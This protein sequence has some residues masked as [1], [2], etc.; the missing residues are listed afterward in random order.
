MKILVRGVNW[1]GDAVMSIPALL[2]LR[3]AYPEA[4]IHLLTPSKLA[5]LWDYL[6]AIDHI[7]TFDSQDTPW[8]IGAL[9]RPK[10]FDLA[11]I[12]PNSFRSALEAWTGA[13]PRR[14]GYPGQWRN[15]LLTDKVQPKHGALRVRKR[16]RWEIR[17]LIKN[18]SEPRAFSESETNHHV[19]H[20]L[21]LLTPLGINSSLVEPK[22]VLLG[23]EEEGIW[24]RFGLPQDRPV[25]ALHPGAEYGPAKRW[26]LA[27]FVSAIEEIHRHSQ[28]HFV[29]VGNSSETG[30][31]AE[32][33]HR[34]SSGVAAVTI[35]A[36]GRTN[37]RD[38]CGILSGCRALI[39]NDTGPMH[40]A[41]AL[42]TPVVAIF[43]ST[44][45]ALTRPL[46][47]NSATI[48]IHYSGVACSPCF[49]RECPIDFRCMKTIAPE[50]VAGAVLQILSRPGPV[51]NGER[52]GEHCC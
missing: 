33:A 10:Q 45:P 11:V 8:K 2:R 3:T 50:K 26:P 49:R 35:N 44:C 31:V 41:A 51:R 12:F 47:P 5:G 19:C 28:C 9:L 20:Y 30:L 34:L 42:G 18:R 22:L 46:G 29:L 24:K 25:V 36:A 14:I 1:L 17:R 4:E 15:P 43:G 37:L 48:M 6:P 21:D 27:Y 16:S 32:L 23:P 13:I 38:L 52:A 39:C 40:V 7:L